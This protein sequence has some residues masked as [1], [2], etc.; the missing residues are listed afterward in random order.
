MAVVYGGPAS[1]TPSHKKTMLGFA[2]VMIRRV[3]LPGAFGPCQVGGVPTAQ[4]RYSQRG[5]PTSA[6]AH[7]TILKQ[8]YCKST[9]PHLLV[10]NVAICIDR[11]RDN[12]VESIPTMPISS[13]SRCT[14]ELC[15][16]RLT[17][18]IK[19]LLRSNSVQQMD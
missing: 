11:R 13:S 9:F 8:Y 18:V 17:W 3:P 2:C 6:S 14:K 5:E 15:K 4:L 7:A 12:C 16:A 1:G 19:S 10:T